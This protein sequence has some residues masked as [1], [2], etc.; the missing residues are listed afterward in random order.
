MAQPIGGNLAADDQFGTAEKISLEIGESHVPGQIEL[1]GRF[2]FFCQHLALCGAKAAQHARAFFQPGC[3]NVYFY[4]VRKIAER[5]ARIVRRE[6]IERDEV[7][8]FF[9]ALA[10]GDNAIV[11]FNG[12][13]DLDHR[14]VWG[15]Q[16]DEVFERDVLSAIHEGA[17]VVA[18]RVQS[19]EQGSIQR[20]AGG[21]FGVGM[22]IVFDSIAEKE[23][24]SEDLLGAV[25]NGLAGD[26]SL[27]GDGARNRG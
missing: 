7:V 22:E 24:V 18:K 9:E 14:L 15:K 20:G 2:K 1:V 3:P 27:A 10:G 13:K 26:E 12:L 25:K 21:Q 19:K 5:C 8:G 17:I 6:V 16:G 11:G 4:E 23:F